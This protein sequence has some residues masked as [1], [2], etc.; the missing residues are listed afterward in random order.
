MRIHFIFEP[1]S[2]R[3]LLAF[4][5]LAEE[6]GVPV[7]ETVAVA[8]GGANDLIAQIERLAPLLDDATPAAAT[9]PW[10]DPTAAEVAQTHERAQ[11][12]L[13]LALCAQIEIARFRRR[14]D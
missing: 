3:R 1:D 10:V 13:G 8:G 5:R 4:G 9:Q 7:V 6:L 14:P 11:R 12:I 2:P